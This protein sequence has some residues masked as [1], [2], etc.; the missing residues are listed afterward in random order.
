[1]SLVHIIELN[2]RI[3]YWELNQNLFHILLLYLHTQ[4]D[5]YVNIIAFSIQ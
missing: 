2:V 4:M 3:G 1:M 5:A